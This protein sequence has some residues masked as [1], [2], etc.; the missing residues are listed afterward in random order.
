VHLKQIYKLTDYLTLLYG[1]KIFS[2][3][4]ILKRLF[5]VFVLATFLEYILK[6]CFLLIFSCAHI[7]I[8]M[9]NNAIDF[10]SNSQIPAKIAA[11]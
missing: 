11:Q 7:H 5:N 8:F 9:D 1:Y 4:W 6:A 2:L 10:A 3:S